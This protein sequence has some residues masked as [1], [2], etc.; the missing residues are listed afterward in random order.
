MRQPVPISHNLTLHTFVFW[1]NLK[2]YMGR[3]WT[4]V[5]IMSYYLLNLWAKKHYFLMT[6][7]WVG[8][9]MVWGF[10]S[11]QAVAEESSEPR[12]ERRKGWRPDPAWHHG[13]VSS[14]S[15]KLGAAGIHRL[16]GDKCRE[17]VPVPHVLA[18]THWGHTQCHSLTAIL[19]SPHSSRS[20]GHLDESLFSLYHR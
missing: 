2:N 1:G 13:D 17:A 7:S 15:A 20:S 18:K 5:S 9:K 12:A 16:S 8:G 6:V 19:M 4:V 11:W 10:D 14:D 3:P